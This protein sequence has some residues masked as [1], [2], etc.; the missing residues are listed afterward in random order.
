[1]ARSTGIELG[2]DTCVLAGV[3]TTRTGVADVVALHAIEPAMWPGHGTALADLLRG[4]RRSK[5][6]PRRAHI[7]AWGLPENAINDATSR[8]GMRPISDAGFRVDTI[9]TP[10]Q[11]LAILAATR[12]K[13][14]PANTAVA[15]LALNTHGAAIAIVGGAEL[16]FAR[17]FQ[18]T[19]NPHLLEAKAQ[20]LQRYSLISHLAPE[21]RRGIT[22]VRASHNV[23]VDA[24]VTCGDLPELRSLTMPLIEELD[25]EVETLDSIE[26]LRPVGEAKLERLAEA[27]PA[28]RLACAVALSGVQRR[29]SGLVRRFAR[30][31]AVLALIAAAAFG[32]AAYWQRI[33]PPRLTAV[34]VNQPAPPAAKKPPLKVATQKNAPSLAGAPAVKGSAVRTMKPLLQGLNK[35]PVAPAAGAGAQPR[36]RTLATP[37]PVARAMTA[38]RSEPKP[39]VQSTAK[40]AA[41]PS[42]PPTLAGGEES[43]APGPAIQT[44]AAKTDFGIAVSPRAAP[45]SAP[46]TQSTPAAEQQSRAAADT[47]G[48]VLLPPARTASRARQVPLKDP[49]PSVDSILIDQERRLA[50]VDGAVAAVGDTVGPRVVVQIER[51]AVVLREPSGLL[52]RVSLR[53]RL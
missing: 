22:A 13:P 8:A 20:L 17:T 42:L 24:A 27:A 28:I 45:K 16:L 49:L 32:V 39:P 29:P 3:R 40:A 11:A 37:Q 41:P 23:S 21:V 52:V 7:V 9:V 18:W 12:S 14:G 2:P 36:R 10:P 34:R 1:M 15:W 43:V 30:V 50:I 26:G 19:Y 6:F 4:I 53:S 38:A 47:R 48:V 46:R 25:L 31:A 5:R 51:D 35:S 33:N 44:P